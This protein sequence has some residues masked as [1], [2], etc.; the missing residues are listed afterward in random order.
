[1]GKAKNG[2]KETLTLFFGKDLLHS[3]SNPS[4]VV[5]GDCSQC[6]CK[7]ESIP[8]HS[9]PELRTALCGKEGC[10]AALQSL[11]EEKASWTI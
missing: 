1:M 11:L 3:F 8:P 6:G 4:E 5:L 9:P 2:T 7:C 10:A